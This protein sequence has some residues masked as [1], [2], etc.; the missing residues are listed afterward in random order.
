VLFANL[1]AAIPGKLNTPTFPLLLIITAWRSEVLAHTQHFAT[2]LR[3]FLW[4]HAPT[5][6]SHLRG[7]FKKT[8]P[9]T[10]RRQRRQTK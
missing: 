9:F 8:L 6:L 5:L 3:A 1:R 7:D 4:S 10:E 2:A